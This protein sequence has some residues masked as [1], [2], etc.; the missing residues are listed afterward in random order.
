MKES[1]LL[2]QGAELAVSSEESGQS[3][4]FYEA[5]DTLILRE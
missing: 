4:G 2:A 1:C 5:V 3:C